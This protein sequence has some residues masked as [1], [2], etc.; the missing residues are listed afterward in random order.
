MV[1]GL[2]H[3]LGV[4]YHNQ[5][6]SGGEKGGEPGYVSSPKGNVPPPP[7]K[8]NHFKTSNFFK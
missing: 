4:V 2:V 1:N 8:K 5:V 6:L 3:G 7:P